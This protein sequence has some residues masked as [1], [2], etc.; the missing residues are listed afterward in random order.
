[1][2]TKTLKG[3]LYGVAIAIAV[4]ATAA[5]VYNYF[6]PPG[7]TYGPTTGTV[8]GTATGGAQGAGTVN[9][10]GV[11]VNGASV[12]TSGSV[13][14]A[15]NPTGTVGLSTVNGSATTFM[16]SDAAPPLS[17]S[18]APTMT[19]NWIFS[20]SSGTAIHANGVASSPVFNAVGNSTS[21]SS[22]GVLINAGTTSADYAWKVTNQSGSTTLA[23]IFG[24]G[25]TVLGAATGG[26]Q[27]VGTLNMTGCFVNGVACSTGGASGANPT[28]TVGLAVVNGSAGT[29]MR[30]DAA[31][32][33]SQ[34]IS[35]TMTGNW[36]FNPSSGV[37][38]AVN[39][40]NNQKAATFAGGATSAQSFGVYIDAG[41]TSADYP[42]FVQNHAASATF[43]E[44]FGDGH[45][46]LGP[47]SSLGF[48]WTSAGVITIAAPTS[49]I[50]LS[51]SG[52]SGSVIGKFI[53][54][55]S[56]TTASND[57]EID[58]AGSTANSI[59]EGPNLVLN[60][61]TN[62]HA[63]AIQLSGNQLE[64]WKFGSSWVQE[65]YFGASNGLVVS[66]GVTPGGGDEGAGTINVS[67]G[68]W[69]SGVQGFMAKSASFSCTSS[70]CTSLEV[71]GVSS[72]AT[73]NS[74]GNYT[75]TF[76][77]VY[78]FAPV[79]TAS[80]GA[81]ASIVASMSTTGTNTAVVELFTST[82]GALV[83]GSFNVTCV[84]E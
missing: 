42:I 65:A 54:G 58:R 74:I 23:E 78:R 9:A 34:A 83:D 72:S 45:G 55:S 31:P 22:L 33:L 8:F 52:S 6:P 49:G 1:M 19:G 61:T 68:Y 39:A 10:Q 67:G 25:G 3:I 47:S 69:W 60:D 62:T 30:S 84:G 82:T 41:T 48:S 53:S 24:D 81:G 80:N 13:P 18:I 17:Q 4:S 40:L 11:F 35:P 63:A 38:I 66:G 37:G 59:T 46:T 15:A 12:A 21:G 56:A 71:Y 64:F 27:G 79:C 7:I 36:T 43:F 26:D 73:R 75:V 77:P 2:N 20:P 32:P 44:I 5:T 70:S 14:T 50:A 16:R 51:T 29:Y 28:G 57:V 76:S